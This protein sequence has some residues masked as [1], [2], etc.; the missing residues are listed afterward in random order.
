M[1]GNEIMNI[2]KLE[3]ADTFPMWDFEMKIL[4]KAK[5]LMDIVDGHE[6]LEAQTDDAKKKKWNS[7]DAKA[8]HYILMTIENKIKPHILS[9]T[10]AKDMYD[11]LKV[12]YQRDTSQQ[13]CT[14]LQE[15]YNFKFNKDIDM[16]NNISQIQNITYKLNRLD[17]KL[18]DTMIITKILTVLPE[19]YKHFSVAWD[20]TSAAEKTLD[21]LKARLL[22]EE[23]KINAAS[24][25]GGTLAF[26]VMAQNKGRPKFNNN[27]NVKCFNCKEL[28][29]FQ[30]NCPNKKF[31]TLC[32]KSNHTE[33]ECFSKHKNRPKSVTNVF[34]KICKKNNHSDKDCYFRD[35]SKSNNDSKR[36][37]FLTETKEIASPVC[38]TADNQL[39][40]VDSINT[41]RSSKPIKKTF[42]IDSGCTPSHMTHDLTMLSDVKEC[43]QNIV[44]AKKNQSMYS[45]GVGRVDGFQCSLDNV[46]YVPDLSKNLMSVNAITQN[47]GKVLFTKNKVEIIKD[48]SVILEGNK[49]KQGLYEVNLEIE[50]HS[51]SETNE[52][53]LCRNTD[54]KLDSVAMNWHR[55]LGHISFNNLKKTNNNVSG[56]ANQ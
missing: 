24:L 31:C 17:Q 29:H 32:K 16:M 11:T 53:S 38:L 41:L 49:N 15:F 46:S 40:S 30:T 51:I 36:T 26:K 50:N 35:K 33:K 22:H 14:L 28:G 4:F 3:D 8:Q 12:I 1:E 20:S 47:G 45:L 44:V 55:K 2:K 34:C 9:C 21:N 52:A 13:K 25:D 7:K 18:D 54:S 39:Q 23:T 56:F 10:T 19:E 27:P 5:E 6:T 42:V 43:K 48:D 37:V